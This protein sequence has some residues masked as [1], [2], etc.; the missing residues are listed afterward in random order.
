MTDEEIV[1][2]ITQIASNFGISCD[3]ASYI[4]KSFENFGKEYEM[5]EA[6]KFENKKV[7]IENDRDKNL[8]M[9][10]YEQGLTDANLGKF[11]NE[12]YMY[13]IE[14]ENQNFI[15]NL[16][17]SLWELEEKRKNGE[18]VIAYWQVKK[19]IEEIIKQCK[20]D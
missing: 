3:D 19:I 2:L 6:D 4:I 5:S 14:V 12:G 9:Q 10:G 7:K 8:Y 18:I 11:Y 1:K 15:R 20:L 13:G 16:Q 17:E